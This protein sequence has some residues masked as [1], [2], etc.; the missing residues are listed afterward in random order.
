MKL[1]DLY[2]SILKTAALTVDKDNMVSVAMRGTTMPFTVKGKRMV[3]PAREHLSNPDKESIVLFH[4]LSENILGNESQVMEKFRSAINMRLNYVLGTLIENLLV[5]GTSSGEHCKL[6]PDQSDLLLVTREADEKTLT[7]WRAILKNMGMGDKD[8]CIVHMFLKRGGKVNGRTYNRAVIV[9]F[10]L[11]EELKANKHVYGVTLRNRDHDTYLKLLEFILPGIDIPH[12]FDRGSES[13]IGPFL[14]ALMRGVMA[15]AS[16]I[17]NVVDA[18]KDF[19]ENPEEFRYDEEWVEAFDN[20]NQFLGEIRAIPM[21]A[22]NTGHAETKS[23]QP[24]QQ[25]LHV[26]PPQPTPAVPTPM[27]THQPA[28]QPMPAANQSTNGGLDFHALMQKNPGLAMMPVP[29]GGMP[30]YGMMPQPMSGPAALRASTPSWALP[31]TFGV[32][33]A[34]PGTYPGVAP[35]TP[36][37]GYMPSRGFSNI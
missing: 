8:K 4:P 15:V 9:N 1:L 27:Q 35:Y 3:L 26:A 31:N 28:P 19:L 21:Q 6:T 25:N 10:P 7:N 20:L 24:T 14:D 36:P 11:Y 30:G 5:L 23:A 13:D 22:G 29:M 16:R 17:N 18:Y 12:H 32:P 34:V 2:K 33:Q 37:Y